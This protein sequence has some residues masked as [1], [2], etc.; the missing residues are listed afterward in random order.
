MTSQ[1]GK[2]EISLIAINYISYQIN[3]ADFKNIKNKKT[4]F[5]VGHSFKSL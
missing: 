4:I 2:K 5:L 3:E 1:M